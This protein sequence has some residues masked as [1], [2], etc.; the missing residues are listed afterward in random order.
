MRFFELKDDVNIVGR[1]HL[2]DITTEMGE[3]PRLRAGIPFAE[4]SCLSAE[5][6]HKGNPIEFCLTSFAV[7]V[8]AATLAGAVSSVAGADVQRLPLAINGWQGFEVL[9]VLRVVECLD[10]Q[11]SEFLKWTE[12]DHRAD[13]AGQYRMVTKLLVDQ[14]GIPAGT[15][16][17]RVKGWLVALVVSENVKDAMETA[18]CKGAKFVPV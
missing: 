12:R 3:P 16:A 15:H 17:F 9:N 2:G 18:G 6:T 8:A 11:R 4:E 7:P 13:L 14:S 1:W 5:I 10:E